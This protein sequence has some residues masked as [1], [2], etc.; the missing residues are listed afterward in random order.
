MV[1]FFQLQGLTH[2]VDKKCFTISSWDIQWTNSWKYSTTYSDSNVSPTVPHSPP[3]NIK[4]SSHT[5]AKE[6]RTAGRE[7]KVLVINL[8]QLPSDVYLEVLKIFLNYELD[9]LISVNLKPELISAPLFLLT[10]TTMT[11]TMMILLLQ[12]WLLHTSDCIRIFRMFYYRRW[13]E[14]VR[15]EHTEYM[16]KSDIQS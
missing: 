1:F 13:I 12:W 3:T 9:K 10:T 11:M 4:S 16:W 15:K 5:R 2:L 8:F 14:Q 6:C 7:R